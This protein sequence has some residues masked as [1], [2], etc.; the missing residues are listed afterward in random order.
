MVRETGAPGAVLRAREA[1]ETVTPLLRDCGRLCGSACCQPD[2]EGRGG[3][4]LFPGEERLYDPLPEGFSIGQDLSLEGGALLLTCRGVCDRARRP[5]AC[6]VFPLAFGERDGRPDVKLDP[7][8]WPVCPLMPSGMTGLS[9]RF[10]NAARRAADILW[11]DPD[12][13]SFIICQQAYIR[14]FTAAPWR[15]GG[16][17]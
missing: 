10:I 16:S 2:S 9:E 12:Q 7:R 11:E 17:L 13:R 4:L 6:R 5:L 15:D 14:R 8:A 1:L 3:M